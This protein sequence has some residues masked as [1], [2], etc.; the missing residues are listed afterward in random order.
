MF[1]TGS[2][3][4]AASLLCY[5]STI[6]LH[7]CDVLGAYKLLH[8]A[9]GSFFTDFEN[10]NFGMHI[11]S[12]MDP[13]N[14]E[15]VNESDNGATDENMK[16]DANLEYET[17]DSGKIV[18]NDDSYA[19]K[20]KQDKQNSNNENENE[21]G[22]DSDG[23]DN[24]DGNN[25]NDYNGSKEND[26]ND[27]NDK[28][29]NSEYGGMN[30]TTPGNFVDEANNSTEMNGVT[31]GNENSNDNNNS[32]NDRYNTNVNNDNMDTRSNNNG[33]SNEI[34]DSDE[35]QAGA[36][37]SVT[38]PEEKSSDENNSKNKP[39]PGYGSRNRTMSMNRHAMN[40]LREEY[41][42]LVVFDLL[43]LEFDHFIMLLLCQINR[44]GSY[45]S[46]I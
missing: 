34:L 18:F 25:K 2:Y 9:Y 35:D 15:I 40:A 17:D 11:V 20:A 44:T 38:F 41:A 5:E 26:R 46:R 12:N 27:D 23:N 22:N 33:N 3:R 8:N 43:F 31:K 36:R 32:D 7:N 14:N 21:D 29:E 1:Y 30:G 37:R 42:S 28:Q 4:L 13:E 10:T 24:I 45:C 6:K 39:P 16:N 19:Q